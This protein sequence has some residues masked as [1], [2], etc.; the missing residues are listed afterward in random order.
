MRIQSITLQ[1]FRN[2]QL[3]QLDFKPGVTAIIGRNGRGKTNI[4]EAVQ[5]CATLSSHR[6]SSDSP[7][8]RWGCTQASIDLH[9]QKH[10]RSVNIGITIHANSSNQVVLNGSQTKK[11]RDIL[12]F[13]NTVVFSPE[14]LDLVRGEPATRRK[15]LDDFCVQLTPR[16]ASVR[17]DYDRALRQR[18]SLLKSVGRKPLSPSMAS[19]LDSW[20]QQLVQL[21]SQL[22]HQRLQTLATLRGPI[23][24]HGQTISG[25]SEP[26]TVE[27]QSS[28]L[29]A[30][31][32]EMNEITEAFLTELAIRRQDELDRGVTLVG[33]HRD[34]LMISLSG[35]PAK[36]HASHG[37]SWSIALAMRLATFTMLRQHDDDP[38]L[39]LDDVFAELDQR[40]RNRLVAELANVEQTLIT[41][42]V[43]DDV[44]EEF[45]SCQVFLA[46]EE[47]HVE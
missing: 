36:T 17:S 44:P 39:I 33:P 19:T 2:H 46:D 35:M 5:Y 47:R 41:A 12:G 40:R 28:W 38:I 6:V 26:L 45:H 1:D 13:V 15:F 9:V 3:T 29:P 25:N 31:V 30:G 16:F 32:V 24:S 21:G 18:S 7:L 11:P 4:V 27:Y 10:D 23:T 34:D 37:Q 42:A 43:L 8:I 22:V 14:D 20:N